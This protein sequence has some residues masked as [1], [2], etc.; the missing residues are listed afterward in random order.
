[1]VGNGVKWYNALINT[2]WGVYFPDVTSEQ[3]MVWNK[4]YFMNIVNT[5]LGNGLTYA[6]IKTVKTGNNHRDEWEAKRP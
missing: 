2:P 3:V 6:M 5:L 1:M 4:A